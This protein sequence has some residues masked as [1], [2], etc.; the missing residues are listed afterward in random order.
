MMKLS[1]LFENARQAGK[2]TQVMIE[3]SY[4]FENSRRAGKTTQAMVDHF[5]KRTNYHIDL[6][7]KYLQKII[8]LDDPRLDN[9]ILEKEKIYDESKFKEPE[10]SPYII[11][12]WSYHQK[13]LNKK[14]EPS[15]D[16]KTK[17]QVASF[18]HVKNNEHHPEAWD[19]DSKVD[20][21]NRADRDTPPEKIVDATKMPLTYVAS[22]IADWCAMSEEKKT[23]P[24]ERAKKNINVRWKLNEDQTK[25]IYDLL[26]KVWKK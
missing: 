26:D 9:Y 12:T 7:R 17:M 15:E 23:C 20:S 11:L 6:E 25:L 1:Y 10:L 16:I 13:D 2:T 21:I 3:F 24:Y 4:L 19:E 14:F 5:H 22:M 8:D 18:H